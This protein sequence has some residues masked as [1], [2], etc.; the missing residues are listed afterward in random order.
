MLAFTC[1]FAAL[2]GLV[3]GSFLNV[4]VWR[5]PR[6]ESLW[7][8]RSHCCACAHPIRAYDNIPLASY[9][10][11]R[12]HCRYCHGRISWRYPLIEAL[13]AVVAVVAVLLRPDDVPTA[14]IAAALIPLV[15]VCCVL[16]VGELGL[17]SVRVFGLVVAAALT[18]ALLNTGGV[19]FAA[20]VAVAAVIVLSVGALLEMS[21]RHSKE[22]K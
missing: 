19:V 2:Y 15:W 8:P 11:L 17:E 18:A 1:V 21:Y 14:A 7:R 13:T 6:G 9:A 12:G 22:T 16:G 5:W 4:L 20:V 3:Y 10:F